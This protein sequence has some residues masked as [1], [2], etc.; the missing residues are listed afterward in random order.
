[1]T[2]GV[3]LQYLQFE[4]RFSEHTLKAYRNDLEQFAHFLKTI[5]GQENWQ[6]V[7]VGQ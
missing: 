4:K 2:I 6:E 3:F 1:M 5:Y 7:T